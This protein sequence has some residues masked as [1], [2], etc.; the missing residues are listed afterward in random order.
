MNK[1]CRKIG[2]ALLGTVLS[3]ALLGDVLAGQQLRDIQKAG[4]IKVGYDGVHPPFA[5]FDVDRQLTG[6]EIE[7]SNALAKEL[8]VKAELIFAKW[9]SMPAFI[10]GNMPASL[11]Y[12]RLDIVIS[13]AIIGE[14]NKR[15]FDFSEPYLMLP[16]GP[17]GVGLRPGEPELLTAVN[18][19]IEKLRADGTLRNLSLNYFDA[20]VTQ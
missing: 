6:F 14:D 11:K 4:V 18:R 17:M 3:V 20:D 5:F 15:S 10:R 19:A 16:Q 13:Q 9:D 1:H 8:G 7:F 12:K 2:A